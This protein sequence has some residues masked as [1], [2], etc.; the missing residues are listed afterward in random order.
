MSSRVEVVTGA[1]DELPTP[2]EN[3]AVWSAFAPSAV[4]VTGKVPVGVLDDVVMVSVEEPPEEIVAGLNAAVAPAGR[5]LADSEIDCAEPDVVVV[6]TA[7][8]SDCPGWTV[9]EA[10][11]RATEKSLP[12]GAATAS[13]QSA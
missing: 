8:W 4:T 3:D 6:L 13:F 9:P 7:T 11:F 1:Q 12:C 10:G 5:P 2:S